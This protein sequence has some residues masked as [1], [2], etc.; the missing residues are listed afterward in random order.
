MYKVIMVKNQLFRVLPEKEFIENVLKLFV[1]NGYDEYYQF[2]RQTVVDKN[3]IKKL[4]I[5]YFDNIFKKIYIPCKYKNYVLNLN[6]KKCIT[7]LRQLIKIENYKIVSN[8]KYIN[9]KKEL[10]YNL[11]NLNKKNKKKEYNLVLKFD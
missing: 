8:E 5:P 7:L 10:I 6:P 11:E 3:I 2:S 4:K 1:P 9:G